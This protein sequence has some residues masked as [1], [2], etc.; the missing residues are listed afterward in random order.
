IPV[1]D[2][3]IRL[4]G[5]AISHLEQADDLLLL[6]LS[7]KGLQYKMDLFFAYCGDNF[8]IINAIKS[9]IG[10]HGP[11]PEYLPRFYFNGEVVKIV[12]VYTYVG[13]AFRS[14]PFRAFSSVLQDHFVKKSEKARKVA[15][16]VLHV[17]SM[18]GAL[19]VHE[20]KI[21]YMGCVDPHLI[22]GSEV[23]INA[24][25][26]LMDQVVNVQLAFFRRLL[27]LS[28]TSI[29]VAIYTETGIIPLQFRWLNL[30]LR[31]LAYFLSRPT[32]TFV[33]AALNESIDL[34][35]AGKK[36]WFKGLKDVIN[37]LCPHYE[38]PDNTTLCSA[39]DSTVLGD[40]NKAIQTAVTTWISD[41][42]NHVSKRSY[43][44]QIRQEPQE[45]G[46][47]KYH[48]SCLRHY[49]SEIQ[50]P[51]HRKALTRL[52]TGD[53]SLAVVRLNWSDNHRLQVPHEQRLC[54]FCT[55]EVETPEHALLQC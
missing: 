35:S 10:Y 51:R 24:S 33:R 49:L 31:A 32:N 54:R 42:L 11:A 6:A 34:D 7:P 29:R 19:P 52:I 4:A 3:D 30:A 17:E 14:G 12:D 55:Q 9:I 20:G 46:R 23:A 39:S 1:T 5:M 45:N 2:D 50:N 48:I 44:L 25:K 36:S 53:H 18:I 47:L 28:K 38:L 21:L 40:F 27:G 16:A 13:M 41:E 15:H 37:T 22:Y 43:L 26:A 8:L